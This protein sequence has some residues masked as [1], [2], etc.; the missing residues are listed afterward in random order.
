MEDV[1][2]PK[3]VVLSEAE[4]GGGFRFLMAYLAVPRRDFDRMYVGGWDLG[5]S[6]GVAESVDADGETVIIMPLPNGVRLAIPI[7]SNYMDLVHETGRLMYVIVPCDGPMSEEECMEDLARIV[8]SINEMIM[9]GEADV[10]EAI[11][12]I[13][14]LSPYVHD[15]DSGS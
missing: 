7:K 11:L 15:E 5:V 10:G 9:G 2:F 4:A 8:D 12:G 14:E 6:A 1:I 3:Y 13:L